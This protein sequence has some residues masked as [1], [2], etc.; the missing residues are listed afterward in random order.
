MYFWKI[1]KQGTW[2]QNQLVSLMFPGLEHCCF[3]WKRN[4]YR[5]RRDEP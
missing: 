2:R 3:M 5:N 1:T 4:I